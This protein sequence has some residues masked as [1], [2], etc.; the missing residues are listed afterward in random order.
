MLGGY[1]RHALAIV[2]ALLALLT[3]VP[4]SA[5]TEGRNARQ[6]LYRAFLDAEAERHGA[7]R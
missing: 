1:A 2:L 3:A 4:A 5:D 6:T 7:S